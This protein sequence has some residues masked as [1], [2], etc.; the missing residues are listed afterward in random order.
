M[1]RKFSQ[2]VKKVLANSREEALRLSHDYIGTEHILLGLIQ[3][4]ETF[5]MRILKS[6]KLDLD[7]L[8]IKIEDSIPV[9]KGEETNFQVGNLPLNKHAEKVLKF[10]YLEA[11]ITKEEEIY[12]EHLILSILKHHE[13]LASN[14]LED[15][16]IDYDIYRNELEYLSQQTQEDS[17][18]DINMDATS[19][20]FDEEMP[21]SSISRKGNSKS[22]T[23]VLDN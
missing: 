17:A 12:P 11:K 7:E 13:N 6:L 9:R 19:E 2:I 18:P 16:N 20:P 15:F 8:K 22:Q 3:E 10:T 23:P 1:T 5:A 21:S 14:I 4:K